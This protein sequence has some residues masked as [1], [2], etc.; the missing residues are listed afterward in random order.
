ME[1]DANRSSKRDGAEV[2]SHVNVAA[3][4]ELRQQLEPLL[5][6]SPSAIVITDLESKVVAWNP[7]AEELFGY[8]ADEATGR[9]LDDLVA[10]TEEL[11]EAASAFSRRALDRHEIRTLTRRT[12]KDGTLVDVELRAAPLVAGGAHIGTFGIY[13]DVT[14]LHRQKRFYEALVDVSPAAVVAI[15]PQDRV[16][17]WNPA[18]ERLFGYSAGEASGRNVDDLVATVPEVREEAERLNRTVEQAQIRV[19][20]RRTRKDGTLVDVELLGA[21]VMIGDELVGRYAIYLDISELQRRKQYYEALLE[22]SPTAITTVDPNDVVTSW[23]PAAERLF[24]YT[25]EEAIGRNIDSLVASREDIR[26]EAVAIS[27]DIAGRQVRLTTRRTRKDGTL[28]DV[29]VAA[30]PIF[31]G[32]ALIGKYALYHDISELQ[33]QRRYYESLLETSPTAIMTVDLDA[34]VTSW[35]PAAEQLLGYSRE[36]A[37]GRNIDDLVA[38]NEEIRDEAIGVSERARRGGRVHL[39]TRRTRKD[40]SLVDVDVVAAPVVIGGTTVGYYAMYSDISEIQ[41]Q[42]QYYQSVLELSPVAIVIV[43]E[44]FNITSWNPGAEQLF[45]YTADEAMGRFIDDLVA[46]SPELRDEAAAYNEGGY[47]GDEVRAIARRTRKD[48]S[49][50]DVELV[51]APVFVGG[52]RVGHSVIYH[53]VSEIQRQRRYYEALVEVSP[54]A[55]VLVDNQNVVTSWN[56]AAERLF[57]YAADEAVGR[58]ILDLVAGDPTVREDAEEYSRKVLEG[59]PVHGI[60][61]RSRKDGSVIDVEVLG[62]PVFIGGQRVGHYVLYHDISEIQR[63]RQYYERLVEASP[64]AVVLVDVDGKTVNSWNPAAERLF[65]YTPEEAIGRNIEDLVTSGEDMRAE[66]AGYGRTLREDQSIHA[67]TTRTRKDGSPVNVEVL[68]VPVVLG[69]RRVGDYVLYHDIGELQRARLEA[70]AATRAKSAFLATM[71]HEIRTPLNAVIGMTGL[72][73]DTE[74]TSEQRGFGEVIRTSGDA[75]LAVINEILDFSKIEA[76]RLDLERRP[77]RL[78]E[79]VESALELVATAAADKSLDLAYVIDPQTPAAIVGDI[80]RLR[81]ILLNLM[82]NAVKFTERG[83]VVLRVDATHRGPASGGERRFEI[84]FAVRDTGIG[85]PEDRMDRLFDAF[86]QVD[87]S[88]T[89]RYGGTGLGLAIV[90]KILEEHGGKLELFDAPDVAKGG[91]GA[92]MRLRFAAAEVA[93][94]ESTESEGTQDHSKAAGAGAAEPRMRLVAGER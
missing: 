28:V 49:L 31:V 23:N 81:Q 85:I 60:T 39:V 26:D 88:T 51:A 43:D 61:R 15:D 63:Q 94:S 82:N 84:H 46:N 36:E 11:H 68:G 87:A 20:T 79:C 56:P 47:R 1:R 66:A 10:R 30:A 17:L 55:V 75:L 90:G 7:A 64:V 29:D 72:L 91:R 57:G 54:V 77:F 21:P 16:T 80:A 25:A 33:R 73:L 24:G 22:L 19:I 74:L 53:D 12:R 40:G 45:G 18:A 14:E 37:I 34:T 58:F 44:D 32:G 76:G 41:R 70:E 52:E 42:R 83:E 62:A 59:V 13:H 35:N 4:Q 65:G 93:S 48:G 86:T 71:S 50:V 5:H 6:I 92:W 69:G 3:L 2:P 38:N 78:R 89:R 27:D 67:V 8:T 9:Y